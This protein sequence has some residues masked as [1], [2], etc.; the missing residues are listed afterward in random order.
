M[1]I[2]VAAFAVLC[3]VALSVRTLFLEPD[4]N[5]CQASIIAMTHG[6]FLTLSTYQMQAVAAQRAAIPPQPDPPHQETAA[7][8]RNTSDKGYTGKTALAVVRQ[9][10]STKRLT[11]TYGRQ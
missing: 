9:I 2:A 10:V 3:V 1:L 8:V 11:R 7:K 4:D 6:H 5:A